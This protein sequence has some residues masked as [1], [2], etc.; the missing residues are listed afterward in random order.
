HDPHH[1][2]V[3]DFVDFSIYVDAPEE[4][5]QT[6][7]INRFLKFREGAFTDPDS[8][9]HNYAKLSKEEAVN[10]ATSLWKEINWLNL[11]QNILPTRERASLIMTKSANHA[12]EQVRLRK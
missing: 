9:F 6:W 10:T 3:S 12:V 4:L 8:Y 1:V 5:L 7:Y 11:K 2:F